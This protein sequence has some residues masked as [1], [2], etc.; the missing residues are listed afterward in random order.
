MSLFTPATKGQSKARIAFTGPSGSG[1][2][3][4]ALQWATV[5]ADGAPIAGIDTERGSMRLYA[6]RFTFDVLEMTDPY[7]P[8][9]LVEALDAAEAAGYGVVVIDSLTHFWSG[10]GGVLEIV[11]QAKARYRGN[12]H[13]AWQEGTPIQQRMV[14]RILSFNGH[15]IVTMRAR[16]EWAMETDDRGRVSPTKV[17][18]APQQR[19][20]LEYEF[21]AMLD[22]DLQHRATVAKTRAELLTDRVFGPDE[23]VES[24]TMFKGWLE[25]GVALID[26]NTR[27]RINQTI[28]S[29]PTEA[30]QRL[31]AMWREQG[32][33]RVNLLQEDRLPLV[34]DLIRRASVTPVP[35]PADDRESWGEGTPDEEQAG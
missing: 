3:Y 11:D 29:L 35:D 31:G 22:V 27:G 34:E 13:A 28:A 32:L 4:T 26:A 14:D 10:K 16:T 24:A 18:L 17:G 15:V 19:D 20:G 12:S 5:L 9:R 6:D 2:T 33:P 21:T 23:T 30:S 1:K 7:H 25:S 8:G